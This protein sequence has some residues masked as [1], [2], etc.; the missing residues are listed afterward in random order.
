MFPRYSYPLRYI[1]QQG[2]LLPLA[3]FILVV[4]GALALTISRTSVQTQWASIQEL[5]NIQAFYAAESGAQRGMQALFLMNNTRQ[6]TDATCAAMAISPDFSGINGLK[7]CTAQVSCSCRY[8]DN[9]V[10]DATAA[11]NYSTT[12]AVERTKSFYTLTSQGACGEQQ[13][14]SVRTIQVS[15]FLNQE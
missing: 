3:L 10:C 12:A 15:A 9:S 4:M 7:I 2:F 1:R 11:A 5:T 6:T 13:F 8:Q 14:R